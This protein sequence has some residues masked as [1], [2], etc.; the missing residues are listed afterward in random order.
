MNL[1]AEIQTKRLVLRPWRDEDREPFFQLNIDPEVHEFLTGPLTREQSD[2]VADRIM[3]HFEKHGFCWWAVEIPHEAP[4]IGFVGL[5][6][7]R[8]EAHFTPCVEIGW[9]L[10]KEAWGNGYAT[11]AARAALRN[12]F[13]QL[14]LDEIVSLT[15]PANIR[16]R[17]VMKKIGMTC[18]PA[19]DFD[20]PS[21]PHH[22]RLSH[23]VLYRIT[24]SQFEEVS[25]SWPN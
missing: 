22:H 24:R 9:R 12:G 14:Q 7:P 18:D 16:S 23:H 21:L 13:E 1:P 10:T 17:N 2:A 3:A 11:E 19:D 15:V 4:F 20:H 6:I 25:G 5:A 8:Y